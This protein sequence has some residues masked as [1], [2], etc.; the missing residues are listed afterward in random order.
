MNTVVEAMDMAWELKCREVAIAETG[1][2]SP[3]LGLPLSPSSLPPSPSPRT[4][5]EDMRQRHID[6]IRRSIDDARRSVD[7]KYELQCACGVASPHPSPN[8]TPR[9]A[10]QLKAISHLSALIAGFAMI[11]MVEIQLP[12]N[13]HVSS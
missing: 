13:L 11:V 12:D 6:N 10:Q 7:E 5:Q 1:S 3:P 8:T 2:A 9:R 4:A